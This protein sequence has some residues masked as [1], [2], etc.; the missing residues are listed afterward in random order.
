MALS[1]PLMA[2]IGRGNIEKLELIHNG[3]RVPENSVARAILR[4]GTYCL[5]TNS[6]DEIELT[7][8]GQVLEI[9]LGLISN[10]IPGNYKGFLTIY[11]TVEPSDPAHDGLAWIR[12]K[13]RAEAW[14]VCDI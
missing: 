10:L 9:K 8:N 7:E 4:F 6:H 3:E 1:E 14:P 2:Y 5:D 13:V 12:A 11:P